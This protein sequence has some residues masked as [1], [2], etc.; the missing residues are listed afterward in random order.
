MFC[1][2]TVFAGGFTFEAAE[3]VCGNFQNPTAE[4]A[5]SSSDK[6]H[7]KAHTS[8]IDVLDG[9]TSL[10]NNSLLV[11]K[12]QTDGEP[13][14]RMLEVVREYALESLEASGEA[15]AMRRN[16]ADYFLALGEEAEPN[17]QRAESIKWLNRL[18]EEQDNIRAALQWSLEND[19][20]TAIRLTAAIPMFWILH[21]HL[22]EGRQWVKAASEHVILNTPS[23]VRFKLLM[24][25]GVLA[26]FQG[27]YKTAQT[28]FEE[29][30]AAGEA[31][32]DLRQIAW[33]SRHLGAVAYGDGD[34]RKA[35]KFL[36]ESLNINRRLNDKSGIAH[37]LCSLGNLTRT[38]GDA[39]AARVHYEEALAI[40][41]QLENKAML[42]S[43][44]FDL[45]AIAYGEDDFK[46]AY[47][48]FSEALPIAQKLGYKTVISY[49]LDGFAALI[50]KNGESERAAQLAG[51]A[52][53]LRESVGYETD[54]LDR[55]F[56]D[57]YTAELRAALSEAAFA[58][59]YEQGRKLKLEEAIK[60]ALE[61]DWN[62]AVKC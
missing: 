5:L 47:S 1:R 44:Q 55:N 7:P 20:E 50:T 36:E 58:E 2:L 34:L 32:N 29:G 56:R 6:E 40:F 59:F 19:A 11:Q 15:E 52:D 4:C 31:T 48:H 28:L 53:Q 60:L 9:I 54:S 10:L 57:A 21:S 27:D 35:R 33:S 3:T 38:E 8:N 41:S 16:L 12:E 37:T 14:F 39:A 42:S 46:E 45:G 51:A 26:K 62:F 49:S 13:R 61:I 43:L 17:L 18:E 23:A 24:G 22:T 30:L 25:F